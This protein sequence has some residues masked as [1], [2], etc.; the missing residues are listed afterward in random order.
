MCRCYTKKNRIRSICRYLE[1]EKNITVYKR[2]FVVEERD[3]D[4]FCTGYFLTVRFE[5]L[6]I[7][8]RINKG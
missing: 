6:S 3:L 8:N 7:Q 4:S 2:A 5:S 1:L